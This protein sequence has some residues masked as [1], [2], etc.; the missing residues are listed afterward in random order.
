MR[1]DAQREARVL[2]PDLGRGVCRIVASDAPECRVGAAESVRTDLSDWLDTEFLPLSVGKARSVGCLNGE[3]SSQR[4]TS[5]RTA[6]VS[7]T[8][9]TPAGV[10]LDVRE[11]R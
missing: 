1:V 6:G 9:R 10:V 2:V 4:A 11:Q 3:R 8:V 7:S 5:S